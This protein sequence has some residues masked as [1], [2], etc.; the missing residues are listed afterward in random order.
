MAENDPP[1][2]AAIDYDLEVDTDGD[3]ANLF[4]NDTPP[5]PLSNPHKRHKLVTHYYNSLKELEHDL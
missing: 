3:D 5:S 4:L 2:D 1:R